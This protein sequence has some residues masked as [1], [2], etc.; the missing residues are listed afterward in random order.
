MNLCLQPIDKQ[1]FLDSG[2]LCC[3]IHVLNA[4]LAPDGGSHLKNPNDNEDLLAVNENNDAE[5]RP[6]RQ[7]EVLFI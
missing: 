3:L 2:I 7:L 1:S 6:V 4:L 5:T